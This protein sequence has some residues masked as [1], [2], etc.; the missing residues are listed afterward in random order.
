MM[1]VNSLNSALALFLGGICFGG[2][3]CLIH[4]AIGK[5]WK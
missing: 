1:M 2:G 3:W 5:L 4:K